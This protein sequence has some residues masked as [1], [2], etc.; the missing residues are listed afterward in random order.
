M[1]K[2]QLSTLVAGADGP[3]LVTHLNAGRMLTC[4]HLD[5]TLCKDADV[6]YAERDL[7]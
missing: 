2:P 4:L 7:S 6:G 5:A 1:L 3:L